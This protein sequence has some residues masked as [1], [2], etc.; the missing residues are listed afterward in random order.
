MIQLA[1]IKQCTGCMACVDCCPTQSITRIIDNNGH[2]IVR[3]NHET[4]IGCHKCER[5]CPA[6]NNMQYSQN[7]LDNSTPY[8]AY[9]TDATYR[10]KA[11]SG[12]V[13]AAI[14]H[15]IISMGGVVYGAELKDN[16]VKHIA[17][18]K[19]QYIVRLQGSKYM[20]SNTTGIYSQV[21]RDLD[22]NNIVL[23][24]GVG[25][26][27]AALLSYLGQHPHIDHLYTIDIIC[28]GVPSSL[29]C[30]RFIQESPLQADKIE[31]FRDGK[32][33]QFSY[34][35][36]NRVHKADKQ[37]RALP[38]YG[39]TSGLTQRYSCNNCAFAGTHRQSSIT[40]GDYWGDPSKSIHRSVIICHNDAGRE[41]LNK[42]ALTMERIEWVDFLPH[43]SRT[44]YGKTLYNHR[45]ERKFLGYI[46][47]NYSYRTIEKIYA[48]RIAT[49]DIPWML[50]RI[51]RYIFQKI[52]TVI[53]RRYIKRLLNK[54]THTS[55]PTHNNCRKTENF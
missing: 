31:G 18:D 51:E 1:T 35:K 50:Y 4:C 36:N 12:G 46:F 5:V 26:Q 25:C 6:V 15:S 40:I 22:N 42:S 43:N 3:I 41:L 9:S 49:Y 17:I 44:A 27:V 32:I 55:P 48:T 10:E 38:L 23:F 13:F 20:Q 14:A 8:A 52:N 11:S 45:I 54:N 34:S 37:Q 21:K 28:G 47:K 33:Y 24:S 19:P 30:E 29:L 53:A 7:S 39:Y 2:P 16:R